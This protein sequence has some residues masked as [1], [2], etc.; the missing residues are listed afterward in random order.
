MM[1]LWPAG[2]LNV[3]GKPI[4][5]D[6]DTPQELR[7]ILAQVSPERV[8]ATVRKLASFETRHTLSSQDF[9]TRGISAARCWIAS[10]MEAYAEGSRGRMTVSTPGYV[11]SP[12]A[13]LPRVDKS[14]WVG[15]V[16]ARLEGTDDPERVYLIS[17]HMDTRCS[18]VMDPERLQPGADDDASGVAVC[19]E[20]ARVMAPQR[21]R[22]TLMF[23]AVA[24]EEQGLLGS[25]YLARTFKAQGMDIQG[26]FTLDIVGS[27]TADDGTKDPH[28]LRL[29]AQGLPTYADP[30]TQAAYA[31]VGGENDSPS[32][33]LAR[34]VVDVA[35]NKWTDMNVHIIYRL[36]RFLR[37]G[38]HRPFLEAGYPAA[39]F[40][41]PNENYAHQHQ[42][43]RVEHGVQYGDLPEFC[44]FDYISRVAKVN[45]AT[46]F[47]LAQA[48]GTPKGVT[49]DTSVLGNSS[50]VSWVSSADIRALAGYEVLW[51]QTVSPSWTNVLEVGLTDKVTV[52]LSKDNVI[53][54]VRAVGKNGYRS[55]A[56]FPLP[57]F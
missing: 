8:E 42:D 33:Q 22:A 9:T 15:N 2:S 11:Q 40:T 57:A 23:V 13:S 25:T 18:D 3:P 46:L 36:D 32:R 35:S 49:I 26:M 24:G 7:K 17:G 53:F 51:R 37:A 50:T 34:H 1:D 12:D 30:N 52:D 21:T 16:V 38:D 28:S 41:E 43:V 48:P 54:G 27:S 45:V 29:F 4:P 55:P 10:E 19:M 44:D 47:S 6:V 39:R 56:A 5:P 14:V 31:Q 20:V